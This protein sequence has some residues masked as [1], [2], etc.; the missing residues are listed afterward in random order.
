MAPINL[1]DGSQASEIVLPDGSTAS[2][3]LAPDGSTVFSTIPDAAVRQWPFNERS[4]STIVENLADDDGTVSGSPT[5][6]ADSTFYNGFYEATDGTDDAILLPIGEFESQ[7]QSKELGIAFTL[8][9]SNGADLDVVAGASD[10]NFDDSIIF[11][12]N[13]PLSTDSGSLEVFINSSGNGATGIETNVG[14][15]DG[16]KKR[17]FFD[18]STDDP[19]NWSVYVNDSDVSGATS[20]GSIDLSQINLS[21]AVNDFSFGARNVASTLE[22]FVDADIDHPILYNSPDRQT[23]TDDYQL[24]PF[25]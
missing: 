7:L 4:G 12:D 20:D 25:A 16:S 11:T 19:T 23:V 6:T 10:S 3:V 22:R 2:E 21:T 17:L 9:A 8:R 24:Q 13:G 1:P 5:N 18:I 15:E 14:V